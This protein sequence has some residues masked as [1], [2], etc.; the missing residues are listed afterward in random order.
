[1]KNF[2]IVVSLWLF[3]S[4]GAGAA[5]Q[6]NYVT[7]VAT[8]GEGR[9]ITM[10]D[11]W[12]VALSD[13]YEIRLPEEVDEGQKLDIKVFHDGK[14]QQELFIVRAISIHNDLCRL[15]AQHPSKDG[16]FPSNA[17]YVQPCHSK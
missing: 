8:P 6:F 11:Y 7:A 14:W 16:R 12:L 9:L 13:T 15:H 4:G 1:M 2:L 3:F 5:Q 10:E 17:I